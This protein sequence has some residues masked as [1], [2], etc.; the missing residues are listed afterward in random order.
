MKLPAKRPID[1]FGEAVHLVF[2]ADVLGV[3]GVIFSV[4]KTPPREGTVKQASVETR[5]I[6]AL[7]K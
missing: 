1:R 4:N 3:N 2:Q 5:V 7:F 6:F